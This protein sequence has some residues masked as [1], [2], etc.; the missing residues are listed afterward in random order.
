[1]INCPFL[2][3]TEY[4]GYC[5][6]YDKP[7]NAE[8]EAE[9]ANCIRAINLSKAMDKMPCGACGGSGVLVTVK[10]PFCY[11]TGKV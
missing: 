4:G 9:K 3:T 6:K 7:C 8:T 11:G 2:E 5:E 1:M 10:C